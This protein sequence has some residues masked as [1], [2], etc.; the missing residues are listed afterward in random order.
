MKKREEN[1]NHNLFPAF[2]LST[3]KEAFHPRVNFSF[4]LSF[5]LSLFVET[6][7]HDSLSTGFI[8]EK[9]TKIVAIET[10]LRIPAFIPGRKYARNRK[11]GLENLF[12]RSSLFFPCSTVMEFYLGH[13]P[14]RR[15]SGVLGHLRRSR[16]NF[17]NGIRDDRGSYSYF[18]RDSVR[19]L[20][21]DEYGYE[22][23][24]LLTFMYIKNFKFVS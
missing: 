1:S 12:Y 14:F 5:S 2:L 20:S 7:R 11:T 15:Y 6:G 22:L 4:S 3:R 18:L 8:R 23:S 19:L 24:K 13:E 16:C 21:T 17:R 9:N 10:V